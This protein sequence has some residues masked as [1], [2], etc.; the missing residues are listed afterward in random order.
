MLPAHRKDDASKRIGSAICDR[1][2]PYFPARDFGSPARERCHLHTEMMGFTTTALFVSPEVISCVGLGLTSYGKK[3]ARGSPQLVTVGLVLLDVPV[4]RARGPSDGDRRGRAPRGDVARDPARALSQRATITAAASAA[5]AP[6][7]RRPSFAVD[8]ADDAAAVDEGTSWENDPVPPRARRRALAIERELRA[9]GQ[10][11]RLEEGASRRARPL[12][13]RRRR[14]A[15]ARANRAS[16]SA[17]SASARWQGP[18]Q[19]AKK[20][21]IV[22]PPSSR[23]RGNGRPSRRLE[24]ERRR[25][26]AHTP[27]GRGSD[28]PS[29]RTNAAAASSHAPRS[30][31]SHRETERAN[32]GRATG[33]CKRSRPQAAPSGR[34]LPGWHV[35][36][37]HVLGV[38]E[39]GSPR[40]CRLR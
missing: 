12:P 18:H 37:T 14:A 6:R 20:S 24:L 28:S 3:M 13:P 4:L 7:S 2:R 16:T 11:V 21:T 23:A 40:S 30:S 34:A 19:V 27:G 17:R 39:L 10:R 31:R 25:L 5:S 15:R 1:I 29:A 36:L 9:R 26:I 35:P 8:V 38:H 32:A 22:A 33:T